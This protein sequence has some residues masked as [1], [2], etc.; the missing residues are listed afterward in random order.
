MLQNTFQD[1]RKIGLVICKIT[2]YTVNKITNVTASYTINV[3]WTR[4]IGVDRICR[5]NKDVATW[6][7]WKRCSAKWTSRQWGDRC[8]HVLRDR[9]R[10]QRGNRLLMPCQ[11]C[12]LSML[13]LLLMMMMMMTMLAACLWCYP[14]PLGVTGGSQNAQRNKKHLV[15]ECQVM[16]FV[17]P[18]E[19][20]FKVVV[21]N[22]V[23]TNILIKWNMFITVAVWIGVNV[24]G[25]AIATK[26]MYIAD[27]P[28]WY[29]AKSPRPTQPGHPFVVRRNEYCRWLRPPLAKKRRVLRSS[30]RRFG[31]TVIL[32]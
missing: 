2:A 18:I 9:R 10:C 11:H 8:D 7:Q 14:W 22:Y 30:G 16:K 12:P 27:I 20:K 4:G 28:S 32:T 26:S 24:V 23:C 25:R 13:L 19:L 6:D 1:V 29:L 3:W 31:T 5:R 21:L 17:Q 15:W